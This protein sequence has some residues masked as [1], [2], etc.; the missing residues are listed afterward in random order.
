MSSVDTQIAGNT[1]GNRLVSSQSFTLALF[2]VTL[3]VSALLLFSVQPLFTKMVL[4]QL[5]GSPSVWSVAMVF[6]QGVLLAGYGY[7]HI[8]TRYTKPKVA[9]IIHALV[10][11]TAF[12][13]L[14]ITIS[15][16]WG[17]PPESGQAFWLIGLFLASVGLPFFAVSA[18]GPLLQA[19][20][21]RTSHPHADDP[22]FL[23]GASNVGSFAALISYPIFLEP[24]FSLGTQAWMWSAG[25]AVLAVLIVSSGMIAA[26]S[27]VSA[28]AVAPKSALRDNV[29]TLRQRATWVG[30]AFVPSGLLVAVTQHISTDIAAAPFLWVMP[31]ALF[32]LTFVITFQRKPILKHRW[33]SNLLPF[34]VGPIL[35]SLFVTASSLWAVIGTVILHFSV[36]FVSAMVCHGEL[37]RRRPSATHLTEFYL[38]MSFGGVLGGIFTSLVAP[39]IFSTVVEYPLLITVVFL[40]RSELYQAFTGPWRRD[41]M[42]VFGIAG[43]L[44]VPRLF[45]FSFDVDTEIFYYVALGGFAGLVMLS[46]E[47]PVRHLA[48]V[49]SVLIIGSVYKSGLATENDRSFFGVNKITETRD[50]Q[51]RLLYQGTTLHGAERVRNADGTPVTGKPVP[52]TYYYEG[53]PLYQTITALRET[54]G[55][56]L[57]VAAVGLG[58]GSL[59]CAARPGDN[60]KFFEIDPTVVKIARDP[61]KFRFM[62]EC[63]KD[64]PV[65]LGDARLTI[66]NEAKGGFDLII[67]D[68][69]SSDAIPLHLL[70]K[71][72]IGI[73]LDKLSE[74]G[75][76]VFH[77]S[78]RHMRLAEVVAS[79]AA[80]QDMVTFSLLKIADKTVNRFDESSIVAII[81]RDKSDLG[82]IASEGVWREVPVEKAIKPWTD[83]YSNIMAAI[84]R[85]YARGYEKN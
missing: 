35:V 49:A 21:S 12:V 39:E 13:A 82:K 59:A 28:A 65:I 20:F 47:L 42:I 44:L 64:M 6:F 79:V 51:Y 58:S 2:T 1:G 84:Y 85:H 33:M 15:S 10:L 76:I 30:L 50:G 22:Y 53:G 41:I 7:A 18:N 45:G 4:P 29:P 70:T 73:Y 68:A 57:N 17:A 78:N 9:L 46:R 27:G 71:E 60:W 61:T 23:Y 52:T 80:T 37:V 25:F 72:A 40:C 38:W 36:F 83:D 81:A 54:H 69:F 32:L 75:A 63:G 26:R 16:N 67:L 66:A 62:S 19:W 43:L 55:G 5:G 77:I 48:L 3:F 31:L 11:L 14:P 56:V 74:N 24:V 8:L 34:L